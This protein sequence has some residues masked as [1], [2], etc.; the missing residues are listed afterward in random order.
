MRVTLIA[1]VVCLGTTLLHA[2]EKATT[3]AAA[4][5]FV[6]AAVES[7]AGKALSAHTAGEMG[8]LLRKLAEPYAKAKQA[9]ER[10]DRALKDK[11]EI[12]F[13]N[14]FTTGLMPLAEL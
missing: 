1:L 9:S 13:K 14:R 6:K 2:Q 7:G 11:T 4:L 3:P 5:G 8:A 10:L 12:G